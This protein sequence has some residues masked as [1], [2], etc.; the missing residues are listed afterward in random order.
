MDN[1]DEQILNLLKVNSRIPFVDIANKLN[2]S[3]G[4]VRTRVKKL[5]KNNSLRFTIDYSKELK[6]IVMVSVAVGTPT[7]K[8]ANL[9]RNLGIKSV[10]EVSGQHDIVCFIESDEIENINDTI[11]KIRKI[12]DIV[13]TNTLIVLK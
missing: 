2:I 6:A 11:E 3:E 1:L 4:T 10:Y 7:T 13:D 9:I 8:V 5:I 12:T